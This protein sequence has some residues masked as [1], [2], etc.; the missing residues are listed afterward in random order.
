M[1]TGSWTILCHLT[2]YT[3]KQSDQSRLIIIAP[4]R[5]L[6]GQFSLL[7]YCK[8]VFNNGPVTAQELDNAL[9]SKQTRGMMA[10]TSTLLCGPK[11]ISTTQHVQ[12][13]EAHLSHGT[14]LAAVD[15]CP[16]ESIILGKEQGT[17]ITHL[18]LVSRP[19]PISSDSD[20]VDG[21][22]SYEA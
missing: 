8:Q 15:S 4:A 12:E 1:V 2:P 18:D 9:C 6:P 17:V 14:S 10:Q 13:H 22:T 16:K 5:T 21:K 11:C 3:A 19:L 7:R 20:A